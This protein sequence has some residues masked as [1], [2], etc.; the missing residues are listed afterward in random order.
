[1]AKSQHAPRYRLLPEM[2]HNMR[3]E[4]GLTQRALAKKLKVSQPWVHKSEIGERRVDVAEF[5]DWCL[6]CGI[7]PEKAL[8]QLRGE[9]GV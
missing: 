4:A 7:D 9:R 8:R 6:A 1:M 5:M 3:E 2:L